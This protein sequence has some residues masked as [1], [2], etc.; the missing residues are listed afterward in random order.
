MYDKLSDN[1]KNPNRSRVASSQV[2]VRLANRDCSAICASRLVTA[3]ISAAWRIGS[4]LTARHAV[5][6]V[7]TERCSGTVY[8]F[9]QP[10][11][12]PP[13]KTIYLRAAELLNHFMM[14]SF[15]VEGSPST[16]LT[17]AAVDEIMK[18]GGWK[19]TRH[20]GTNRSHL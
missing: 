15:R 16:F 14:H 5:P 11:R 18:T 9:E 13:R 7:S 19:R 6:V 8:L 17:G 12:R 3:N 10:V 20:H 1:T 4:D 2:V